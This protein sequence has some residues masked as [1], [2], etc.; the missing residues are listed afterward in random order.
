[1]ISGIDVRFIVY[2]KLGIDWATSLLGFIAV[3]LLP[4]PW[5]F[6]GFG[7]RIRVGSGY[8]VIKF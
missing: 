3:A 1:L 2:S 8:D 5:V 7:P 4:V 6:F